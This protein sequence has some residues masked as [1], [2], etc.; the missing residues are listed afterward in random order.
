M[1]TLL[2]L[3][4]LLS[5]SL[6]AQITAAQAPASQPPT[7]Q[8]PPAPGAPAA[9]PPVKRRPVAAAAV[10]VTIT[11]TEEKGGA[12]IGGV[13]VTA[14]SDGAAKDAQTT[15]GGIARF[16]SVKPG[17]YRMRFEHE[18][19]ITLERDI[20]VK[21]VPM[22]LTVPLSAAPAPPPR[23]P[24]PPAPSANNAAPGDARALSVVDFL[25]SNHLSGRDPS[26]ADQLGCTAS[27]K[28]TLIQVRDSLEE[29][30]QAD[31][32]EVLYVIAGEG[33]LR[34][35][36]KDVSLQAGGLAVV[37]R[38]TVRGLAR[39]GKNPLMVLSVVS[40]PPCTGG[41]TNTK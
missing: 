26:R 10:T 31:A 11:V 38:G 37:P 15:A 30:S 7:A 21:G 4:C 3:S 22:D 2:V 14:T 12:P 28:T 5:T 17:E 34:L 41:M 27:A 20:V 39:K 25:E 6:G 33:T 1:R 13:K 23:T 40:G 24:E 36:N 29:K 8:T 9:R 32:D 35:G 18:N 19:Y 16:L